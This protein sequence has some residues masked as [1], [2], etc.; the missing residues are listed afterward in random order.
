MNTNLL[1]G[2]EHVFCFNGKYPAM[3]FLPIRKDRKAM[4]KLEQINRK[5]S[6]NFITNF[7]Q[8][9]VLFRR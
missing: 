8:T 6:M 9:K 7:A 2:I 4:A 3:T 1:I 5:F